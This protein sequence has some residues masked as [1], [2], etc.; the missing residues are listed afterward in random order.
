MIPERTQHI[1]RIAEMPP[2]KR[3]LVSRMYDFLK[4]KRNSDSW[5][6]YKGTFVYDSREYEFEC[7]V[8]LDETLLTYRKLHLAYKTIEVDVEDFERR[9]LLN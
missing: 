8:R 7:E 6:K 4:D 2:I 3:E 1:E 5:W 9:G